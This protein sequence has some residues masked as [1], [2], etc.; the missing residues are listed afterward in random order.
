[1][2][3]SIFLSLIA[4]AMSSLSLVSCT[5]TVQQ[6]QQMTE[7][8]A[9]VLYEAGDPLTVNQE[10]HEECIKNGK[11]CDGTKTSWKGFKDNGNAKTVTVTPI[12]K[13]HI[14]IKQP[15]VTSVAT[16]TSFWSTFPTFDGSIWPWVA[17][18]A[19]I[20]FAIWLWNNWGGRDNNHNHTHKHNHEHNYPFNS[21]PNARCD[22]HNKP[23][24]H[25]DNDNARSNGFFVPNAYPNIKDES[26]TISVTRSYYENGTPRNPDINQ[27]GGGH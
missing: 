8:E 11:K 15:V 19:L 25:Q 26:V 1:M 17:V 5:Q 16:N 4:F 10:I 21:G 13:Q 27:H 18:I 24:C 23:G 6:S 3:K 14:F 12:G 22:F 20:L 2:K 9:Q 7:V